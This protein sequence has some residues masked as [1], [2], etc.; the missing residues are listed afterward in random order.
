MCNILRSKIVWREDDNVLASLEWIYLSSYRSIRQQQLQPCHLC[1]FVVS[2]ALNDG[3]RVM[4]LNWLKKALWCSAVNY[5][6]PRAGVHL[7]GHTSNIVSQIHFSGCTLLFRRLSVCL[8]WHWIMWLGLL[9]CDQMDCHQH[10]GQ[11]ILHCGEELVNLW[12]VSQEVDHL[13]I[14]CWQILRI[15]QLIIGKV[16]CKHFPD[17]KHICSC[18]LP[19]PDVR[20]NLSKIS[21]TMSTYDIQKVDKFPLSWTRGEGRKGTN[22]IRST[23]LP[24]RHLTVIRQTQVGTFLHVPHWFDHTMHW[25][26]ASGLGGELPAR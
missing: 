23:T 21:Q 15:I 7:V 19:P 26:S 18:Q 4:S 6:A 3:R 22:S 8:C 1:R 2:E 25:L 20:I 9:E 14:V 16:P 24:D 12:M 17:C 11:R 10:A 5:K 13:R